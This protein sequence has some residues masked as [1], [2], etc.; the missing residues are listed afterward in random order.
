MAPDGTTYPVAVQKGRTEAR[1]GAYAPLTAT[2]T[3]V[4]GNFVCSCYALPGRLGKLV[5]HAAANAAMWA[6][7]SEICSFAFHEEY[8]EMICELAELV[9]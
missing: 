6:V 7:R 3:V 1:E 9:E 4:V 8:V 5:S 2:G